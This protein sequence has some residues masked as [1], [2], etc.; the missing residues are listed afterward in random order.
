MWA[1]QQN[2]AS[3]EYAVALYHVVIFGKTSYDADHKWAVCTHS[4]ESSAAEFRR[5]DSSWRLNML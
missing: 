4:L 1:V 5:R 2:Y 3:S